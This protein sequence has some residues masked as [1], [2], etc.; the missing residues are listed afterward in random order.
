MGVEVG[1]SFK[2]DSAD[3][4]KLDLI[5]R[6]IFRQRRAGAL[7]LLLLESID[8]YY[9]KALQQS[10]AETN[11]VE[12]AHEDSECIATC[13]ND[14]GAVVS[15]TGIPN[16]CPVCGATHTSDALQQPA[17]TS[18]R[19]GTDWGCWS[20]YECFSTGRWYDTKPLEVIENK[21]QEAPSSR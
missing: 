17:I 16:E 1:V 18:M 19:S 20:C 14:S 5:A 3:V 4:E 2:T 8:K 10:K 12:S 7:R 11:L 21:L 13:Q 6:Q 15:A 9:D